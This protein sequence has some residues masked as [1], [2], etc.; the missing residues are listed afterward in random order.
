M[1]TCSWSLQSGGTKRD[2]E[3]SGGIGVLSTSNER[4]GDVRGY[5]TRE[6]H[7][8]GLIMREIE[9]DCIVFLLFYVICIFAFCC[10]YSSHTCWK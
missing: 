7:V 5:T 8:L 10:Y 2:C 4:Y 6:F 3:I 9:A 1:G